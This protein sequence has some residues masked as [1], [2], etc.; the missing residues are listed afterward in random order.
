MCRIS[1]W[2]LLFPLNYGCFFAANRHLLKYLFQS[3]SQAVLDWAETKHFLPGVV[4][5][6]H[7]FGSKLNF[8]CHIHILYTLGGLDAKTLKWKSNEFIPYK[9][10]KSRFKTILLH[11]LRQEFASKNVAVPQYIRNEWK[12]TCQS[13]LFWDVQN[14]LY[15]TDWYLYIGEKLDNVK[16]T[17]G[18]IGRYAKRPAIAETRIT[19]YS[20][21][22]NYVKFTYHDKITGE[23]KIVTTSVMAFIGLLV[24]HIPEKHFH[25]IRY[26]GMY[27]NARKGK[28]FKLIADQLIAIYGIA[29]LLFGAPQKTWR[30]RIKELTGTDPLKCPK[31]NITMS[32]T[33]VHYRIRDGTM[34]TVYL[35]KN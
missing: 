34:K 19:Y 24:R 4:A 33:M 22:D 1:T 11:H 8:N 29:N 10:L 31:C 28:I 2:Y 14:K 18:Y 7:T 26:Y 23:D 16:L 6:L 30:R 21:D 5:V 27:A 32:L 12:N 15:N 13:N 25:M 35:F 20:Q 17:V 9:T 3:A